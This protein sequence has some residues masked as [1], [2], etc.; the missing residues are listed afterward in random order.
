MSLAFRPD[1][2]DDGNINGPGPATAAA[3]AAAV[4]GYVNGARPHGTGGGPTDGH[5]RAWARRSSDGR[6]L[7]TGA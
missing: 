4:P 2:Y 3:G 7:T 1:D 6:V 5:I